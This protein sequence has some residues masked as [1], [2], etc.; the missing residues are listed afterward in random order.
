M[1]YTLYEIRKIAAKWKR[2]Y[3]RST[4]KG[5]TAISHNTYI[6]RI[7]RIAVRPLVGTPVT[8]NQITTA[9]LAGGLAAAAAFAAGSQPWDYAGAALFVVA[10]VLDR[11]D[12][13]LARLGGKTSSWGHR[14]DLVSDGICNAAVFIGIGIGLAGRDTMLGWWALPAGIAA[15]LGVA[16]ILWMTVW[17]EAREGA[18]AGELGGAGGFDPDDAVLAVPVVMALGGAA[19]LILA[20]AIC[21]PAF[22]AF[23][24]LRFRRVLIRQASDHRQ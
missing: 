16:L 10:F 7:V 23:F 13:E 17:I 11:A 22:A 24:Y 21:A 3:T 12:G 2:G 20:A 9:R 15:G 5:E 1:L 6:H 14:Y 19:P 18:R 8:P 4:L